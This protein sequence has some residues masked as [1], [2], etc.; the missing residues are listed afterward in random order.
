M[1]LNDGLGIRE[2]LT[3]TTY[4]ANF[5][6]SAQGSFLVQDSFRTFNAFQ[7][8]ELG[9]AFQNRQGRWTLEVD[10]KI[11]LGTTQETVAINGTTIVTD[12]TGHATVLPGGLL[13]LGKNIGENQ[14]NVFAVV[15]QIALKLGYQLTPRLRF[16]TAYDFLYWSRVARAGSQIDFAVNATELPNSPVPATPPSRPAFAFQDGGFWA[17]GLSFGLD[18]GW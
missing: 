1:Q 8:G 16:T 3:A 18:Y 4:A 14:R 5:P 2:E 6:A 17:Q 10:P 9:L 13:A 12:N 15:P 7:G 11:A